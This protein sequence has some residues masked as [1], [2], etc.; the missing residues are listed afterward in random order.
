[1]D[2]RCQQQQVEQVFM[3]GKIWSNHSHYGNILQ[4]YY[5]KHFWKGN[6]VNTKTVYQ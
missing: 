1:M 2:G 4:Q 5:T 6:K 3:N